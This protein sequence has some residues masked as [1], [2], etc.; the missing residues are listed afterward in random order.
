MSET[1]ANYKREIPKQKNRAT[2]ALLSLQEES[3]RVANL[4]RG[5]SSD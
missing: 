3:S 2:E 5:V 4:N 1:A